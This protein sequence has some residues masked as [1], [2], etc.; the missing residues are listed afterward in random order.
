MKKYSHLVH[1]KLIRY[2]FSP[3]FSTASHTNNDAGRGIGLEIVKQLV[4]NTQGK[5]S[6]T[7]EADKFT[8]FKISIPVNASKAI[9]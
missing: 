3:G 4:N 6:V 7:Y 2:I 1:Q 9:A 8:E 5:I